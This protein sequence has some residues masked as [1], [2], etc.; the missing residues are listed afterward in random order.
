[1]IIRTGNAA[2]DAACLTAENTRQ[3]AMVNATQDQVRAA[4]IVFYRAV[5]ASAKANGVPP[6]A[7]VIQALRD[8]GTGGA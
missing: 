7:S 6:N 5:I 1:M 3:G 8:L 4:E 2:H